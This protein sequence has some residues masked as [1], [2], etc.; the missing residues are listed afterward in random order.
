MSI[1]VGNN[2]VKFEV[3]GLSTRK[4]TLEFGGVR[5]HELADCF[6]KLDKN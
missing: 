3:T 4:L 2:L 1:E 5:S 6:T